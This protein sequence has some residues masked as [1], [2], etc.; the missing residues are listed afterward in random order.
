[1]STEFDVIE[2][3]YGSVTPAE[4]EQIRAVYE[5]AFR[6]DIGIDFDASLDSDFANPMAYY[7]P[8]A[9]GA[10]F[11]VRH[12]PSGA[13]VGTS[14]LRNIQLPEKCQDFSETERRESTCELKR[15]FILPLARGRGLASILLKLV[16]SKAN[17]LGYH[18]IVLDTKRRLEA[19][20]ALYSKA[21]FVDCSNYNDNPRADRF[22]AL[23]I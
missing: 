9:R 23:R 7:G 22:M 17:T 3:N 15:M 14:G 2:F 5:H 11:V 12:L 19:A 10:F 21:G 18:T 20:N 4:T 16:V 13:I 8:G 6:H 1:M